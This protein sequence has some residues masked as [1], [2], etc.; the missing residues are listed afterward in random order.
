[1]KLY[2]V[3]IPLAL[4]ACVG[5][6]NVDVP[7]SVLPAPK[8]GSITL[9]IKPSDRLVEDKDMLNF[10]AGNADEGKVV[11]Y[12]FR[13]YSF[14]RSD[15]YRMF[16]QAPNGKTYAL[17][18][19]TNPLLPTFGA[20]NR[21]V[22]TRHKG[23]P[24][25]D[26][27]K[28]FVCCTSING[29]HEHGGQ[30]GYSA[31]QTPHL[32]YGVWMDAAGHADLFVGGVLADRKM[33]PGATADNHYTPTGKATFEL[34]ALRAKDGMAVSSTYLPHSSI[35]VRDGEKSLMTVNF[36]TGQLVGRIVGDGSVVDKHKIGWD[37]AS[38]SLVKK[39]Q[40]QSVVHNP[41]FGAEI[42]F[43][44]QV[45]GNRF[46]GNAMSGGVSGK[47]D[48]AFYGDE[49]T[50]ARD[51]QVGG[52]FTF[53]GNHQLNAVFG[54]KAIHVNTSDTSNSLEHSD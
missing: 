3:F 25:D 34:W 42:A 38:S 17:S 27:G 24:T 8:L 35:T 54:G 21:N 40:W 43:T 32:R 14:S 22:D 9:P 30:T 45:D 15:S 52:K 39:E 7:D 6:K 5:G 23:Q 16:Y 20:P 53:D 31:T 44:G 36:N 26:D 48:G 51:L 41:D 33:L 37:S 4:A 18:S 46:H 11:A 19:Y 50:S 28:L 13:P 49:N 10:N 47:L 29:T 2:A 12:A 1:M